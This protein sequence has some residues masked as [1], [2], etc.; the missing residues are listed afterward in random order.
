MIKAIETRYKGYKFRSRLEA[1]W[2]VF[3]DA[4]GVEWEYETEGYM[5]EDGTK[6]LPDFLLRNV[7]VDG[8]S[9]DIFIEVKGGFELGNKEQL[10]QRRKDMKK[11]EA[12]GKDAAVLVV[13]AIPKQ[14]KELDLF[15][16][17]MDMVRDAWKNSGRSISYYSDVYYCGNQKKRFLFPV[18]KNNGGVKFVT[19]E[20]STHTH[21]YDFFLTCWAFQK[22]QEA[23]FEH[24]ETPE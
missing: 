10:V 19:F 18:A 14:R 12:F 1:R 16:L 13:G 11:L 22:A 24:G 15:N 23:R 9:Q 17:L 3:F 21:D 2:A 7:E 20:E 8:K 6:Y 4:C 5:L